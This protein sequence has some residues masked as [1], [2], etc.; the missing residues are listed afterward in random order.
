M[1]KTFCCMITPVVLWYKSRSENDLINFNLLL[2]N[3]KYFIID[4]VVETRY[5]IIPVTL[6]DDIVLWKLNKQERQQKIISFFYRN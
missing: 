6:T 3:W 5:T 1:E 2:V 4:I